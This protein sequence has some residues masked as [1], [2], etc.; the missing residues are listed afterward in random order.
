MGIGWGPVLAVCVYHGARVLQ[1]PGRPAATLVDAAADFPFCGGRSAVACD[2]VAA[3]AITHHRCRRLPDGG[4]QRDAVPRIGL[5]AG[6][7]PDGDTG[8]FPGSG[9]WIWHGG[10]GG[11]RC[12]RVAHRFRVVAARG[13]MGDCFHRSTVPAV[14][15]P[16]AVGCVG[17]A[18][19]KGN[20]VRRK[21]AK[22]REEP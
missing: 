3:M 9:V 10:P 1:Q 11:R 5:C 17:G 12:A 19:Q 21:W 8:G 20:Q 7:Y 15:G 13:C 16:F 2:V 14:C 4:G 18:L 6:P 22:R